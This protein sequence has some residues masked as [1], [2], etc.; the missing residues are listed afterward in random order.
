[1]ASAAV[2]GLCYKVEKGQQGLTK[3]I[4]TGQE[5]DC[6]LHCPFIDKHTNACVE[7]LEILLEKLNIIQIF[8]LLCSF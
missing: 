7:V 4:S 8:S 1:M 3:Y 2:R 5:M 6:D